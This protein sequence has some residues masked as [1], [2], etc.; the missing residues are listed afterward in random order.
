MS[1]SKE[2]DSTAIYAYTTLVSTLICVPAALIVEGPK[3]SAGIDK[4]LAHRPDFYMALLS[5]GLLYHLYNQV[6]GRDLCMN[7]CQTH[8]HDACTSIYWHSLSVSRSQR[9]QPS[10]H[11]PDD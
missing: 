2:L 4:A 9:C 8:T 5:V 3:L 1:S 11:G 7:R 6:G 10:M